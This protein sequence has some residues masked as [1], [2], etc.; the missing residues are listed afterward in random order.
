[1]TTLPKEILFATD[2]SDCAARAER[3]AYLL[4]KAGG[5]GLTVLHV[6]ETPPGMDMEYAVNRLYLESLQKE[7][8]EGLEALRSRAAQA[9]L[10]VK[11]ERAT[12]IPSQRIAELAGKI[13]ADLLVLG[14]RGR[15]GLEHVLLGSTA[16]RTV[17][18]APCPVL[19]VRSAEAKA[20][21]SPAITRI[22]APVDFS[23]CSLEALEYAV[24]VSRLFHAP[25]ALLH[26]MEPV[27]YGLDFT[28]L[29]A[30]EARKTREALETRLAEL[31]LPLVRNGLTVRR[32]VR[33]GMPA[34]SILDTINQDSYDL[35]VMGTHG[36]RGLS[37][38]VSG[39]VAERVLRR[40]SC[41]V[42]TVKSPKFGH[43]GQRT[44]SR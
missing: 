10:A 4:A 21:D 44:A 34:D 7:T 28:L 3:Y 39:S 37:H 40:A 27:A 13:H 1:M 19:T 30:G 41:P 17:V 20:G 42:L 38:V 23:D 24:Q 16:E 9:G 32:L 12:G 2:F 8:D 26:V 18:G 14:T 22:L 25:L 36:R 31:A 6:L 11:V 35:V 29:A 33:G 15:T 43:R 5:A